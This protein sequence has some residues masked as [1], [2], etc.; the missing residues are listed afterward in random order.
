MLDGFRE[1]FR[2]GMAHPE[3][4]QQHPLISAVVL[5]VL[6]ALACLLA[7]AIARGALELLL[8]GWSGWWS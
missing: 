6:A 4:N 7:G 8:L 2:Q 3:E 1:G 5:V